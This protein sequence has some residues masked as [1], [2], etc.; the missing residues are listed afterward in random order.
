MSGP[1]TWTRYRPIK[2]ALEDLM[3][4]CSAAAVAHEQHGSLSDQEA[5]A[6]HQVVVQALE[7]ATVASELE[8]NAD[9]GA[10]RLLAR[11]VVAEHAADAAKDAAV[12]PLDQ[13]TGYVHAAAA[14]LEMASEGVMFTPAEAKRR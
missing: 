8:G 1:A 5:L 14:L 2:A 7:V 4:A 11:I 9:D 13:A 12:F 3:N 6:L 10:G